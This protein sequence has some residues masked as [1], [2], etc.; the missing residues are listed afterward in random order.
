[1]TLFSLT[2]QVAGQQDSVRADSTARGIAVE[3]ARGSAVVA[4]LH[5]ATDLAGRILGPGLERARRSG[6][7]WGLH[8][9]AAGYEAVYG[10]WPLLQI[11]AGRPRRTAISEIR[12]RLRAEDGPIDALNNAIRIIEAVAR[13][14][15]RA[16]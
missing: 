13:S 7:P 3:S 1:M 12:S 11:P 2:T 9:E 10:D 4:D 16:A 14:A 6:A 8:V 15:R 5:A